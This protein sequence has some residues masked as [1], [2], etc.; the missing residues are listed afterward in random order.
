MR[1]EVGD[2]VKWAASLFSDGVYEVVVRR[3]SEDGWRYDI[4]GSFSEG[5]NTRED[6]LEF[7]G[8]GGTWDREAL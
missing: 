1:F 2:K 7:V 6:D 8:H 4:K 3:K 5:F